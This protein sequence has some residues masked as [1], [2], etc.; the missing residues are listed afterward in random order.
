[1]H[2]THDYEC[3]ETLLLNIEIPNSVEANQAMASIMERYKLFDTELAY[4]CS[5]FT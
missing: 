3:F 1:M 2:D 4:I 5:A